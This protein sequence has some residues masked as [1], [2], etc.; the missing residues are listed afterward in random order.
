MR[1]TH[2]ERMSQPTPSTSDRPPGTGR[3]DPPGRWIRRPVSA[4]SFW[5]A[6]ALPLLY[7]PLFYVGIDTTNELVAFLGLFG[8]HVLALVGGRHHRRD[9][10]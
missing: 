9:G 2:R 4:I 3:I 7:L 1:P 6:I 5:G 10:D 8:V